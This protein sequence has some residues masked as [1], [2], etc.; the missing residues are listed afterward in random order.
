MQ[1][2]TPICMIRC[3]SQWHGGRALL[4]PT[5]RRQQQLFHLLA[6]RPTSFQHNSA[7]VCKPHHP[8]SHTWKPT[9]FPIETST[10]IK[11]NITL[12]CRD[13]DLR[14]PLKILF[15][16]NVGIW[17][18]ESFWW[19]K[20]HVWSLK[21]I[22]Y[23]LRSHKSLACSKAL[24]AAL[25][26][27]VWRTGGQTDEEKIRNRVW[28]IWRNIEQLQD[29]SFIKMPAHK[30]LLVSCFDKFMLEHYC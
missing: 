19:K 3:C 16:Y 30:K 20:F 21:C 29:I 8:E 1:R 11:P 5:I 6:E 2:L 23:P 17:G 25:T 24:K 10:A 4:F 26:L 13:R 18:E 28:T 14:T 7:T 15:E 12:R 22:F 9:N 27:G